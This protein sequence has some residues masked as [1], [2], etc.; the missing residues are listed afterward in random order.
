MCLCLIWYN[1]ILKLL[2]EFEM[3]V[4]FQKI[5]VQYK[6]LL[7]KGQFIRFVVRPESKNPNQP[8][9]VPVKGEKYHSTIK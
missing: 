3:M 2:L 8:L 1:H 6:S 5:L 7:E 9:I 4:Q